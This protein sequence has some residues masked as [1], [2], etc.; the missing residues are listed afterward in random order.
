MD[1]TNA[2]RVDIKRVAELW[3]SCG[4]EVSFLDV[5]GSQLLDETI[6]TSSL[7]GQIANSRSNIIWDFAIAK[8]NPLIKELTQIAEA[9]SEAA[10]TPESTTGARLTESD[11]SPE[12]WQ[13]YLDPS[14]RVAY[15]LISFDHGPTMAKALW[16]A[17][18]KAAH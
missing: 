4:S 1:T 10:F 2:P 14:L 12:E 6:F 15:A 3:D 8:Q 18:T 17:E 11:V 5:Y 9:Y 7:P 13:M 16:D